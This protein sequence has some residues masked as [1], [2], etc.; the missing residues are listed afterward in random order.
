[1][2]G[3]TCWLPTWLNRIGFIV[4][5]DRAKDKDA[6]AGANLMNL[7]LL[8]HRRRRERQRRCRRR[9][10]YWIVSALLSLTTDWTT[11]MPLRAQWR[12]PVAAAVPDDANDWICHLPFIEG[13][14]LV[15]RSIWLPGQQ[16]RWTTTSNAPKIMKSMKSMKEKY[17]C[18]LIDV[19]RSNMIVTL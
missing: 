9:N 12:L 13:I 5:D 14:L 18:Y 16:G 4:I 17:D 1:M 6:A 8:D 19:W 11:K 2:K 10:N 7:Y 3:R 15:M